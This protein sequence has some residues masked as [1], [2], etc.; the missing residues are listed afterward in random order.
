M[1]KNVDHRLRIV[2]GLCHV[3]DAKPIRLHLLV[4]RVF[5]QV[6]RGTRLQA[7]A[8]RLGDLRWQASNGAEDAQNADA[9]IGGGG[10]A[11]AL[12]C[13]PRGDMADLVAENAGQFRFVA[14]Q[15]HQAAG[16]MD[17]SARQREGVDVVVVEDRKGVRDILHLGML[18]NR[19]SDPV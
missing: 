9:K 3:A 2:A 7:A 14:G 12:C 6:D 1:R 5:L 15:R 11:V 17:V 19:L 8:R 18:R 16:D 13:V 10:A 4:A